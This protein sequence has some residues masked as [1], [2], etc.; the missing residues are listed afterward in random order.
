VAGPTLEQT[1]SSLRAHVLA[2]F[3]GRRVDELRLDDLPFDTTPLRHALPALRLVRVAPSSSDGWVYTTLGL[4][5]VT[6]GERDRHGL[7]EFVLGGS[8]DSVDHL[9]ILAMTANYHADPA[10]RLG[11]GHTLPIGQ[12]WTP[13]ATCDHL[14]VSRPY[15]WGRALEICPLGNDHVHF[16][17]L[18]PITRAERDFKAERDARGDDGLEALERLFDDAAIEWWRP[19]RESVV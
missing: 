18:L 9:R 7:Q 1:E 17:W 15:P 8:T 2:F 4:W 3:A 10:E 14:L 11:V 13:G 6:V 5:K 16:L 19:N 12:L